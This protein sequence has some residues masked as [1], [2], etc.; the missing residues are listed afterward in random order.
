MTARST[1]VKARKLSKRAAEVGERLDLRRKT[2]I[3]MMSQGTP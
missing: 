3:G 2:R 1:T